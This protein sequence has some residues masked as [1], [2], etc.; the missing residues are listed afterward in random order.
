MPRRFS[1]QADLLS[2]IAATTF[3]RILHM[4]KTTST[5]SLNWKDAGLLSQ[6]PFFLFTVHLYLIGGVWVVRSVRIKER[7]LRRHVV[8]KEIEL[9]FRIHIAHDWEDLCV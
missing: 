7:T 2:H 8:Q 9:R 3:A 5:S 6:W 4:N 1:L